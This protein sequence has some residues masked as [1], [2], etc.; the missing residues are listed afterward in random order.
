MPF[1]FPNP[2]FST[3]S[4]FV[5]SLDNEGNIVYINPYAAKILGYKIQDLV[6]VNFSEVVENPQKNTTKNNENDVWKEVTKELKCKNNQLCY[7]HFNT[8]IEEENGLITHIGE[9]IT[10]NYQAVE[11]LRKNNEVMQDLFDNS[12]DLIFICDLKGKILFANKACRR[13]LGYKTEEISSL[14]LNEIIY[15]KA[16]YSTKIGILD[17][18]RKKSASNFETILVGK[19][20]N[21]IYLEGNIN[22]KFENEK[23]IVLRGILHNLTEKIRAEKSQNL[24]Y[25]IAN[26]TVKSNNLDQLYTSIHEELGKVIEVNNF[27][28][29][30]YNEDKSKILFPYYTDEAQQNEAVIRYRTAGQGLT[31]YVMQSEKALFL[32]ENEI[33]DLLKKENLRLFG[34]K[35]K[36]WIGV[37]LKFE[38]K[39]IGLISVKCYKDQNTYSIEDLELLDFI[40][41]QIALAIQRKK[42]EEELEKQTARLEAVF[43]SSSHIMWTIDK[44][45]KLTAYNQNYFQFVDN[46]GI[47][48]NNSLENDMLSMENRVKNKGLYDFWHAQYE[49]AFTG[50]KLHF[51]CKMPAGKEKFYWW[52]VFLNPIKNIYGEIEELSAIAHDITNKKIAE[53]QLKE[54]TESMRKAKE[55]AENS[56][57]VKE[58]FLANMSHEIRTPMNGVIGMIDVLNETNLDAQQKEYVN[59]VKKSSYTLLNILN[60]ILDLS[61]IEAGKMKL[62]SKS[63]DLRKTIE[64]ISTLFLQQAEKKN[65]KILIEI[66]EKIPQFIIADETRLLQ[67]ISN[68]MA[69]AIKFTEKGSIT[70]KTTIDKKIN[71]NI[72]IKIEVKDTGIG[73][74]KEN[75]DL[76]FETFSQLDSSWSKNY[77]GTGLGLVISK[78]LTRLMK[79][80]MGV[81]SKIGKGSDFWF[82]FL[83][84][85][86]QKLP[87]EQEK[88][89]TKNEDWKEILN[90]IEPLILVVDD[91]SVNRKVVSEILKKYKCNILEANSGKEAIEKVQKNDFDLILMDIQMPDLDGVQTTYQI[92]NLLLKK[93]PPIIALTA[94]SMK[95]DRQKFLNQGFDDY[96]SK[97]IHAK[98]LVEKVIENLQINNHFF[99]NQT[100]TYKQE[101]IKNI[102]END[103]LDMNILAQLEKYGGKDLVKE[104]LMEF[105]EDTKN[106]LFS[107]QNALKE[108][109]LSI[110]KGN[111]HT[112]KGN[113]GTLG[114]IQVASQAAKI[115]KKLKENDLENLDDFFLDLV[116]VFDIFLESSFL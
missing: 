74:A 40:S 3:V 27:Y 95:E 106:L 114:V 110:L 100:T 72:S 77:G 115:E 103:I 62:Q 5:I 4:L 34:P 83:T 53:I 51:E 85:Q 42:N 71:K 61:K 105:V 15:S 43:D 48:Q 26:L 10:Q 39:V 31:D 54:N 87:E 111:L 28:I 19:K 82:T 102:E 25:S 107:C 46:Q 86:T 73:I 20:G 35:P 22:C 113:A 84:T 12:G 44:N 68:L 58:N 67:I 50:K 1:I 66:S 56:L 60:D 18:I 52:E 116:R 80:E 16:K 41:G 17:I 69:N 59:I 99:E 64:K 70:L 21:L 88:L 7:V 9:N 55:M 79:G 94:Y 101:N 93:I 24:Y 108:N 57:R 30:L 112:L 47:N 37:P 32:T 65:L 92:R 76:L 8:T 78:E 33:T 91:N 81:N 11:T 14:N 29:K 23:P 75:L 49:Q 6:G 63:L 2:L 96:L 98:K 109:N 13:T 36:V 45:Y 38:N 89:T 97:P 90:K 104:S